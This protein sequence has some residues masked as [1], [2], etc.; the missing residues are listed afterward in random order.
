MYPGLP[1]TI[2]IHWS[3]Q[4]S[5]NGFIPKDLFFALPVGITV[6]CLYSLNYYRK[7]IVANKKTR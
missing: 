7:A 4:G 6:V 3:A 5:A 1:D 2:L